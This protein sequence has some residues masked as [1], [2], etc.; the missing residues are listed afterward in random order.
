M[1][2]FG[3]EAF[4]SSSPPDLESERKN[5]VLAM[6]LST[7][8]CIVI[9]P[10]YAAKKFRIQPS[11][12][13]ADQENII[14]HKKNA[15][16]NNDKDSDTQTKN[17][18]PS[19]KRRNTKSKNKTQTVTYTTRT[20]ITSTST[21]KTSKSTKQLK[22][23]SKSD[24]HSLSSKQDEIP[25]LLLPVINIMW[26]ISILYIILVSSNNTYSARSTFQAPLLMAEECQ[27]IIKMAQK[28]AHVNYQNA[29]ELQL[30]QS[31]LT[32]QTK[33]LLRAGGRGGKFC[34]GFCFSRGLGGQGLSK[35]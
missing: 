20:T 32:H 19:L 34:S 28:A 26:L 25:A 24:D 3:G 23:I 14:N 35:K 31:T 33:K 5:L 1:T 12:T 11:L 27:T 29:K 18:S 13:D 30:Q 10:R 9:I 22:T 4:L 7:V 15:V 17:S 6:I 21:Y 2:T 8:I 16:T